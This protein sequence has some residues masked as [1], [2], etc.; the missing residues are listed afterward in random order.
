MYVAMYAT[1]VSPLFYPPCHP[2]LTAVTVFYF[3]RGLLD[4]WVWKNQFVHQMKIPA[5]I[6]LK[7]SDNTINSG[8]KRDEL[9]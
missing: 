4:Q 9:K 7:E 3:R 2:S 5:Q 1:P 6:M 8:T